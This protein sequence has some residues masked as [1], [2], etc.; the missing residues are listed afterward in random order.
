MPPI[1]KVLV[2]T[3]VAANPVRESQGKAWWQLFAK[4]QLPVIKYDPN[5]TIEDQC[6]ADEVLFAVVWNPPKNILTKFPNLKAIQSVG[7]GVDHLANVE[8]PENV[9][10]LRIVDPVMSERMATWVVWAVTNIQRRMDEQLVAQQQHTWKREIG[11]EAKDNHETTVGVMGLGV[12]GGA[13][14]KML[15]NMGYNVIGWTKNPKKDWGFSCYYGDGLP[16][17]LKQ[18]DILVC[19]LP[20][21][22]KTRNILCKDLF[23]QLPKGSAII[24][25]GRGG[26]V[27]EQDLL[28]ALDDGQI[29]KAVLDVFTVEPLPE[30]NPLWVHPKIRISP[31]IASL[32]PLDSAVDQMVNNYYS[33][34]NG[35][36]I[37]QNLIA[38]MSRGY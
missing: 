25:G 16:E 21:T 11:D 9:P 26:H 3:P 14:A 28:N 24:N 15:A 5:Q 19:L 31:H 20:L 27:V 10:V 34:L 23:Y 17:F 1:N 6:N 13:S 33:I 32:T 29:S 4:K 2:C 22:D 30:D 12:M 8:I 18:C 36:E 38:D 7:A 35:K 37:D